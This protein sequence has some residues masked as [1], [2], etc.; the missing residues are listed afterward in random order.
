MKS[1]ALSIWLCTLKVLRQLISGCK[2]QNHSK[3]QFWIINFYCFFIFIFI[4]FYHSFYGKVQ[5]V[6]SAI[7]ETLHQSAF[8]QLDVKTVWA[9]SLLWSSDTRARL[10]CWLSGSQTG[11]KSSQVSIC[12][13]SS[14]VNQIWKISLWLYLTRWSTYNS[15]HRHVW[16]PNTAQDNVKHVDLQRPWHLTRGHIPANCT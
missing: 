1:E 10:F 14:S 11:S 9:S 3:S 5:S 2:V 13:V 6:F 7:H 8:L 16:S 15:W 12:P 4:Y